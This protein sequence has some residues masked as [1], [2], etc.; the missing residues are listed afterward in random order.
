MDTLAILS[1]IDAEIAHFAKT[2]ALI[3]EVETGAN[4]AA[5]DRKSGRGRNVR[6]SRGNAASSA[7][8]L[9]PRLRRRREHE[10]EA[11]QAM[12]CDFRLSMFIFYI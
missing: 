6:K 8:K 7:P 1:M 3:E 12:N 4:A 11:A 5:D 9:G 2:R 10:N